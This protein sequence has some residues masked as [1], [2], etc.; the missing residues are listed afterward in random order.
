[1]DLGLTPVSFAI[2]RQDDFLDETILFITASL[3]HKFSKKLSFDT[4]YLKFRYNE[5]SVAYTF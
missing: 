2:D 4:S 3:H 1:V 5:V